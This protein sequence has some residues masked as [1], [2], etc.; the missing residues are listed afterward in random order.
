MR[1][2]VVNRHGHF[3]IVIDEG[4]DPVTGK[5]RQR[6]I[7]TKGSKP[8]VEAQLNE[9][10]RDLQHG[11]FVK[12][13][14]ITVRD[15]INQ[16]L[17]SYVK[18]NL[19]A[20]TNQNYRSIT[21]KHI[22]PTMGNVVLSELKAQMIQSLENQKLESGLSHSSVIKMHNILH[23]SLQ[24]ALIAGKILNNPCDGVKRPKEQYKE[25]NIMSM[26][27]IHQLLD[28]AKTDQYYRPYYPLWLTSIHTGL[29]RGEDMGIKWGEVNL[30]DLT[31][32]INHS[33]YYQDVPDENGERIALKAPKTKSS[34]RVISIT[35][36][37]AVV[38]REH[39]QKTNE[40]RKSL[41]LPLLTDDD[42]VFCHLNGKPYLPNTITHAWGAFVRKCGMP[43][44]RLHDCRH[45]YA[46]HLIANGVPAAIIA[47]QLGH[48]STRMTDRYTHI[49]Q[50][51]QRKAAATFEAVFK[52]TSG[53]NQRMPPNVVE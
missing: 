53:Q 28:K 12:P 41:G 27:T 46:T 22:L 7:A 2:T 3:A 23:G 17:D 30:L 49:S 37:N 48:S 16:W 44:V 26:D 43:G 36:S 34:R 52:S 5:R 38:L 4:K 40:D 42:F 20:S 21:R 6:W 10:M 31:I 13:A 8:E 33:L 19:S 32:S 51:M 39:Y 24:Q 25:I 35:P 50:E 29:R 18:H 47:K 15:Y 11:T 14:K 9:M 1:G 45:A